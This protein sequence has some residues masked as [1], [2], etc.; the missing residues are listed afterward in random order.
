MTAG[1]DAGLLDL[2]VAARTAAA[3]LASF[4]ILA[5]GLDS[6]SLAGLVFSFSFVFSF[7]LPGFSAT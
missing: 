3:G 2:P 1:F 4:D 6:F 5:A 7:S